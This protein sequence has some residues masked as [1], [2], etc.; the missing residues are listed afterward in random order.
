VIVEVFNRSGALERVGGDVDRLE[1]LLEDFQIKIPAMMK[2]MEK[3]AAK[4]RSARL[5]ELA[6]ELHTLSEGIGAEG[7]VG[8]AEQLGEAVRAEDDETIGTLLTH[9]GMELDWLMRVLDENRCSGNL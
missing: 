1:D 6:K 2:A 7:M 8:L 9:M 5:E 3:A 4:K